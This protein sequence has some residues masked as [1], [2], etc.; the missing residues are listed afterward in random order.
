MEAQVKSFGSEESRGPTL[1][2]VL[3]NA[4]S[5]GVK[6]G[7]S[8]AQVL[9]SISGVKERAVCSS[10]SLDLFPM[11]SCFESRSDG[12][13]LRYAVD[14][15]KLEGVLPRSL[16]A[17]AGSMCSMKKKKKGKISSG[18]LMRLLE[19]IHLKLDRVLAGLLQSPPEG[20]K[21]FVVWALLIL[22][23][24][25]CPGLVLKRA[26]VRFWIRVWTRV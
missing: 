20:G 13:G 14:C 7:R 17:A 23:W 9:R 24:A 6:S 26:R 19:H 1:A 25:K 16:A 15:L 3:N 11:S 10:R 18:G 5:L 4:P 21:E 22:I 8:F 12:E 2:E